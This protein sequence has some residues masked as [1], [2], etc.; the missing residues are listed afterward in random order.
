MSSHEFPVT[1]GESE[2]V[3]HYSKGRV[4]LPD[5]RICVKIETPS[6]SKGF[7]TGVDSHGFYL[8][9]FYLRKHYNALS[10]AIKRFVR[11]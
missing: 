2:Q 8:M 5:G 9:D 10:E 3:F 1:R 7:F 11:G 4:V 6:R